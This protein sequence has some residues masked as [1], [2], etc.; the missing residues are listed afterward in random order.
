M[1]E[2]D[3]VFC[4]V[5]PDGEAAR[6]LERN[7]WLLDAGTAHAGQGTRN[8][9]LWWPEQFLELLWV[10]DS[11]EARSNQLRLDVRADWVSSGASP[12]GI[13][14]R[15]SLPE[16]R[17]RDFWPYDELGPRIWVH[18]DNE[19]APQRPLVFI[20]EAAPNKLVR[21]RADARPREM[22]AQ[23]QPG[24]LQRLRLSGP[25]PG[26][27]PAYQ[28]PP[29]EQ[30][31]GAPHLHVVASGAPPLRVDELLSLSG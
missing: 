9:R 1:L 24:A 19:R 30:L 12:F 7:G 28:G 18:Q 27:V 13:A 17:A 22:P 3:H 21:H 5:T 31:A 11:D 20:L 2:F 8:R 15:G 10:A 23:R 29:I 6:L 26:Q 14:L 16:N 4:M 25:E